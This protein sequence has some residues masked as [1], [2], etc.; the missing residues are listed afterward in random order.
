V[1]VVHVDPAPLASV[2]V[3]QTRAGDPMGT[4]ALPVRDHMNTRTATSLMQSE[5]NFL[6]GKTLDRLIVQGSVLTLQRNECV[7]RMR[8][9]WLLFIDDDMV[10]D[11]G[12]IG[13]LV[14][15]YDEMVEYLPGAPIMMGGLCVRRVPPHQPT[16]YMREQPRSGAYNFLEK[17]ASDVVE[18][19]ATG[20]AFVIIGVPAF[21]AIMGGPMP[22][23]AER[24]SLPPWLFFE[25]TAYMGEDIGFCQKAKDAGV[26]IFVDT[27]IKIGHVGE[28]IFGLEHFWEQIAKRDPDTERM[29]RKMNS[30]M[31]LPTMS[32]SQAK[33]LLEW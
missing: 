28:T 14:K 15:S 1:K 10:W 5:Y 25:W 26:R 6:G 23:V 11:P 27:R 20:M 8:G 18:V 9:D 31:G 29:R 12:Q 33:R 7:Q 24:A 2:S 17:W 13:A 4:L 19:D 16:M 21:E 22:H 3:I 30:K 32:A